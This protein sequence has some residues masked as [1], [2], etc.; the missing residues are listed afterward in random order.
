[1]NLPIDSYKGVIVPMVTP[2]TKEGKISTTF[3]KILIKNLLDNETIPFIL[4]T[5]GESV[6]I[7]I[8]EKETLIEILISA[9]KQG[10]PAITGLLGL[11]VDETIAMANKYIKLGIDSVVLTL[12]SFYEL[13]EIQMFN[14]YKQLA[15]NID[16]NIILYNIPKTVHQSIPLDV[17]EELSHFE[18]IIGIK[19]S[20][21]NRERIIESLRRWKDRKDFYHITGT[22]ALMTLGL[23]LGS[24]ALV[25]ST[26]N[27]VPGLYVELYKKS[28][29]RNIKKVDEIFKQT[30]VWGEIYQHGK[31]LGNSLA[32]LK[33]LLSEMDLCSPHMMSPLTELNDEEKKQLSQELKKQLLS[34]N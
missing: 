27:I 19:D 21:P 32:A 16:G 17:I 1:M 30:I 9:K 20:E 6:S 13:N 33:Y 31:T 24:K 8:Q 22:N 34:T 3:A 5:T 23:E 4:G 11:P 7:P 18:N 25:P 14:Y 26:A 28:S 2:L 12:P 15:E 10:T 29:E